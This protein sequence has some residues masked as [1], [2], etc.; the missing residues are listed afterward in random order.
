MN[1]VGKSPSGFLTAYRSKG[2]GEFVVDHY[3]SFLNR[4]YPRL[5]FSAKKPE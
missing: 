5:H 2:V 4:R 3:G 1:A